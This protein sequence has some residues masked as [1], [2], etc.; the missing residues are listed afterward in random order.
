MHIWVINHLGE[1]SRNFI[2]CLDSIAHR[3][4]IDTLQAKS[5]PQLIS[6]DKS[7]FTATRSDMPL[8]A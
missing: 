6:P 7:G 4:E 5:P 3:V 1:L 8:A 2:R